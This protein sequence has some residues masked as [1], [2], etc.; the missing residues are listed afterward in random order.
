MFRIHL[1][2]IFPITVF[3]LF[4]EISGHSGR[5]SNPSCS[6]PQFNWL[7]KLLNIEQ[8]SEDHALHHTNPNVNFSKQFTLWDKVFGTYQ[9][10]N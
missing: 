10:P 6:F 5:V 2:I 4:I 8:H 1:L 7:P 9:K 3:R